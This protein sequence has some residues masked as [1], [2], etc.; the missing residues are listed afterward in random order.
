MGIQTN[1]NRYAVSCARFCKSLFSLFALVALLAGCD[2]GT[3]SPEL[4]APLA[5]QLSASFLEM[6]TGDTVRLAFSQLSGTSNERVAW[7]SDDPAIAQVDSS[8]LIR[9][10]KRGQAIIHA[11]SGKRKASARVKV[12][13][14]KWVVS[15]S[16]GV[17]TLAG[18]GASLRMKVEVRNPGGSL[19]SD[20]KASWASLDPSIATVDR[21]GSVVAR[22]GG[23]ARITA[24]AKGAVDTATVV[25][26]KLDANAIAKVRITPENSTLAVGDDLRL[27]AEALTGAGA[28]IPGVKFA[29]SSSDPSVATVTD[30]GE[31]KSIAEGE[32]SITASPEGNAKGKRASTVLKIRGRGQFTLAATPE[33]N[34]LTAIGDEVQL[35]AVVRDGKGNT[36]PDASVS[37]KS[38]NPEVATVNATGKVIS[39]AVGLA[40]ITATSGGAMDTVKIDSRQVIESVNISPDSARLSVGGTLQYRA[41]AA[42]SNGVHLEDASF[43]WSS[44]NG[45][46]A[47]VSSSG[48]ASA[49]TAGITTVRAQTGGV[50]GGAELEVS[51]GSSTKPVNPAPG[52][53]PEL[54]RAWV[55]TEY[56]EPTGKI[57]RVGQGDD[58]QSAINS[59]QGGDVVEL[60]AGATFKGSFRL[61]NK[62]NTKWITIR[63]AG[64]LPAAGTRV[65]PKTA[66]NFATLMG[67][68]EYAVR[69]E[70]GAGYYRLI[71]LEITTDPAVS[72]A[73]MQL[74][75][76]PTSH[77]IIVDRSYVHGQP[78][79]SVRRCIKMDAEH[80]AVID[81][82][83]SECHIKGF[84]A[85]AINAID[86]N[87]PLKIV[88]NYLAG[89]GE[90]VMIGGGS[91]RQGAHPADIEIRRN[92]FHKPLEWKQSGRWSVKNLLEFK[93]GKR[94]LIEGNVFENNWKDAQDGDAINI[95]D[96]SDCGWCSTEH[97]TWRNNIVRNSPMG[98]SLSQ[99]KGG[100]VV[101]NTRFEG[102]E[103]RLIYV[104]KGVENLRVEH[105]TGEASRN[106]AYVGDGPHPGFVF[107]NNKV[108]LGSYGFDSGSGEGTKTLDARM[109]GWIF[110]GNALIG[111]SSRRDRYPAG[112]HFPNS[113]READGVPG[114][115]A[116][117]KTLQ[118]VTSGVVLAPN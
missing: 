106:V 107:R 69:V 81:S 68:R 43:T 30:A 73:R 2:A 50:G 22:S 105:V 80:A 74:E 41:V 102:I 70:P 44:A 108:S 46:V 42:D 52:T 101:E 19:V 38:L 64:T 100:V 16:P 47:T 63:S 33:T 94:V 55:D 114:V 89:S 116:D 26:G 91:P 21:S 11:V 61:P 97:F 49:A 110:E 48:L 29:F 58:L 53:A 13:G 40:L 7:A 36:V 28:V 78:D 60:A 84:D 39:R 31:V 93:F 34:V 57:I 115:G 104:T 5:L 65:T 18:V 9:A 12:L 14:G 112:N 113:M 90:N 3:T 62:G 66:A 6:P 96:Q 98:I 99:V 56:R 32:V 117:M 87:G 75:M 85:Q 24:T 37:W 8:G 45:G 88:N 118:A 77:H 35:R 1:Q 103:S 92:H 79:L 109:P 15:I 54:P 76:E 10:Q 111:G 72:D 95:K 86:T 4:D 17:D 82:W 71:G 20:Q 83:V 59:A 67:P 27:T 23:V 51:G 25:V